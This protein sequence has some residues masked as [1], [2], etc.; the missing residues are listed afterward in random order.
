MNLIYGV[1][2]RLKNGWNDWRGGY[3]DGRQDGGVTTANYNQHINPQKDGLDSVWYF[4]S[5][6]G[7]ARNGP[8]LA[9]D[10]VYLQNRNGGYLDTRGRGCND[11]LLCVSLSPKQDR[12]PGTGR[13]KIQLTQN[14]GENVE[15]Q[16]QAGFHLLNGW[17][18]W[19]GGH[20]DTRGYATGYNAS[21]TVPLLLCVSTRDGWDGVDSPQTTMW[22]AER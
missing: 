12:E 21:G 13:W 11:N 5:A 17:N 2:Y 15:I 10:I 14:D 6:T 3:L 16:E 7:K 18:D 19:Q 22:W 1:D 9:N 8:V 4:V 20:L